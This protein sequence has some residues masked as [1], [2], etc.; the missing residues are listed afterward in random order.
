MVKRLTTEEFIERSKAVHGYQYD[1][2]NVS[3][4]RNSKKVTIFCHLHGEFQQTP[5]SH[6]SG[7]GCPDCGK[8]K[9]GDALRK[10]NDNFIEQSRVVHGDKY[11]YEKVNYRST[12][13]KVKINCSEHG[14]FL[15]EPASHLSGNGCPSCAG[16]IVL[17]TEDFISRSNLIHEN[18]YDYSKANYINGKTKVRI[19]CLEHGEFTANPRNHLNGN[20]CQD[21]YDERRGE[22]QRMTLEE[23]IEKALNIHSGKYTYEKFTYINARKKSSI[24][25]PKHGEF[26]QTPDSH[27]SGQGCPKCYNKA[28]GRIASYLQEKHILHRRFHIKNREF[29]FYLPDFNL[30]IERDGEQHYSDTVIKGGKIKAEDQQAND[31]YKTK[32]A[33]KHGYKMARIPYWLSEEEEH[34]EI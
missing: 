23:F 8:K 28:E 18:K 12:H 33:I 27:L 1:Y 25:C 17:N 10:S 26:F 13:D 9:T 15:Q 6:L 20:G 5:G 31:K 21:C 7:H 32:L 11:G 22:S 4:K 29:D 30:I 24:M 3:Y 16:N 2:S 34:R 14:D 19:I